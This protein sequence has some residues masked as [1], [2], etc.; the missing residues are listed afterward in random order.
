MPKFEV[1]VTDRRNKFAPKTYTVE[2]SS[3]LMSYGEATERYIKDHGIKPRGPSQ[4]ASQY[5]ARFWNE[6]TEIK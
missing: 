3:E 5:Y 6:A 1:T 4:R 2:A